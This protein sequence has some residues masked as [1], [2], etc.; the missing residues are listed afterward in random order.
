MDRRQSG[1][2]QSRRL[3]GGWRRV[4]FV[5]RAT[6]FRAEMD[7]TTGFDLA[8]SA[9]G[10]A[11]AAWPPLSPLQLVIRL[12][13]PARLAARAAAAGRRIRAYNLLRVEAAPFPG[14]VPGRS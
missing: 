4:H 7:A 11:P 13:S 3:S 14:K 9:P 5:E 10:R 2:L 8:V 1:A 6:A 12:L